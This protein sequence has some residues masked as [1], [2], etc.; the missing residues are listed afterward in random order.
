MVKAIVT[1][2]IFCN[3]SESEEEGECTEEISDGIAGSSDSRRER[4]VSG[5]VPSLLP[6]TFARGQ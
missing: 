6:R 2:G 5:N 4:G 1:E 3:G